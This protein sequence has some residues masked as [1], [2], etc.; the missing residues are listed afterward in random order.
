M[1]SLVH[2]SQTIVLLVLWLAPQEHRFVR[3]QVFANVQPLQLALAAPD[4]LRIGIQIRMGDAIL[5]NSSAVPD[6][7]CVYRRD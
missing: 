1:P 6:I 7:T 5:K 3:V 2:F 4:M